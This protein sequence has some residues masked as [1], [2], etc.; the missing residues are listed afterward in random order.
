MA[1]QSKILVAG[2]GAWAKAL[3]NP[4]AQVARS[5]G[6]RAWSGVE[7]ITH[8]MPVDSAALADEV[9]LLLEQHKPDAWVGL[10]VSSAPIIQTEMIGINWCDFDVPD[11][12]GKKIKTSAILADGPAAYNATLP[13]TAIVDA[14]KDAGI[15][16]E[17]SFHAGTHLC[18]Q[19]LYTTA[20]KIK[21][22]GLSTRTGFIH[23][24]QSPANIAQN[25]RPGARN[26]SMC[27]DM[28]LEAVSVAVETIA[29]TLASRHPIQI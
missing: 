27:L 14:I 11:T 4:A 2:Y 25:L 17:V 9:D 1:H 19:M 26:A 15:P 23:L 18:N 6:A 12:S 22:S 29:V 10:G 20:H 5:L 21:E 28:T 3:N 16:A 7:V 8:V 13:N 24:P